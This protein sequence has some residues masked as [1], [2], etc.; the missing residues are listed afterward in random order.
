M[1]KIIIGNNCLVEL[2]MV[3]YSTLTIMLQQVKKNKFSESIDLANRLD[4]GRV[5]AI[6]YHVSAKITFVFSN[7]SSNHRI[8]CDNGIIADLYT[9]KDFG[10]AAYPDFVPYANRACKA[11]ARGS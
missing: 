6:Q 11:V 4:V 1:S 8:R 5:S 7:V 9:R 2:K 10:S 3:R